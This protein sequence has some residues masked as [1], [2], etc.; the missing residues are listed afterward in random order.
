MTS[1]RLRAVSQDKIHQHSRRPGRFSSSHFS[2]A[3]KCP[4]HD[5]SAANGGLERWGFKQILRVSEEKGLFPPFFWIF[6]VLFAK[7]EKGR[8]RQKKG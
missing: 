2:F 7:A 5:W 4:N 6:Q 1:G 3:G 8:K